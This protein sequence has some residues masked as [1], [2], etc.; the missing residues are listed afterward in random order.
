MSST[1]NCCISSDFDGDKMPRLKD[2]TQIVNICS[3][4]DPPTH[5]LVT[6]EQSV[7]KAYLCNCFN[8]MR[9]AKTSTSN[10]NTNYTVYAM[11]E[12]KKFY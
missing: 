2:N 12:T 10:H 6:E 3:A 8:G 9:C 5:F 1:D 4:G 11:I 7:Q